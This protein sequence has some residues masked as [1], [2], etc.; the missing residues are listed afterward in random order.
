MVFIGGEESLP[1]QLYLAHRGPGV[2]LNG[3]QPFGGK[4]CPPTKAEAVPFYTRIKIQSFEPQ[5]AEGSGGFHLQRLKGDAK[6]DRL[7]SKPRWGE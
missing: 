7:T 3:C 6:P 1:C 2:R 5:D 4:T